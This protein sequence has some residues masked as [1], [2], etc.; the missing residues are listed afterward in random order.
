[1][2]EPVKFKGDLAKLLAGVQERDQ[3]ERY[4]DTGG[5]F[6][7]DRTR[8][9]I[10]PGLVEVFFYLFDATHYFCLNRNDVEIET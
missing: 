7:F 5:A 4:L 8:Q 9:D 10:E 3:I 2:C 1:M 6:Y